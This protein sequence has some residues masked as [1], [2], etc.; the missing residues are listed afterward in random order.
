M[1]FATYLAKARR[2]PPAEWPCAGRLRRG[3]AEGDGLGE[4]DRDRP[5]LARPKGRRGGWVRLVIPTVSQQ[6]ESM[7]RAP[8]RRQDWGYA[9]PLRILK[10]TALR[11]PRA[12][13]SDQ[14]DSPA[15]SAWWRRMAKLVIERRFTPKKE[16]ESLLSQLV[17]LIADSSN[18][19]ERAAGTRSREVLYPDERS[20]LA[21]LRH[22]DPMAAYWQG[23]TTHSD[24]GSWMHSR[25]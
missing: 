23:V 2:E 22:T 8:L 17:A 10:P 16:G 24:L 11:S 9:M 13:Q 7:R 4:L 15:P 12:W 3:P 14:S 6:R 1:A 18:Y 21:R 20:L 5:V 25:F 19:L